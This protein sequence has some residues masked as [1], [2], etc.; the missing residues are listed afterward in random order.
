[1]IQIYCEKKGIACVPIGPLVYYRGFTRAFLAGETPSTDDLLAACGSSV[2]RLARGKKVVLI[3]GVGYP[4][5][6]S[7]CGTDNA[8]V[9]LACSYPL[10]NGTRKPASVLLVGGSGVG[11][12]VD[13][14]LFNL[15]LLACLP[16]NFALISKYYFSFFFSPSI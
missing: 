2:D 3:D 15:I 8:S 14:R 7:I 1:M 9:A 5:V 13:V 12:A 4:A 6:G 10:D 16:I 11:N